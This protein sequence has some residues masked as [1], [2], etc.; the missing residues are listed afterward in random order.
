MTYELKKKD[1]SKVNIKIALDEI[2]DAQYIE[3]FNHLADKKADSIKESD[4]WKKKKKFV[5]YFLRLGWESYL[6][7]DK[8]NEL[9]K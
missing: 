3:V 9:I 5:D 8:A 2:S 7:Y 1:V 4:I 6:V